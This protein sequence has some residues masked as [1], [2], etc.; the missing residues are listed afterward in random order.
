MKK[1]FFYLLTFL[2]IYSNAQIQ[3][4]ATNIV[5]T[6]TLLTVSKSG[7]NFSLTCN[8][9]SLQDVV[10]KNPTVQGLAIQSP[11]GFV[12]MNIDDTGIQLNTNGGVFEHD[13]EPIIT[14][15]NTYTLTNKT[16]SSGTLTGI[17]TQSTT[18]FTG[19]FNGTYT[20]AA[21]SNT[22]DLSTIKANYISITGTNTINSFGTVQAGAQRT[23]L[24]NG[25]LTVTSSTN[26]VLPGS[27][28]IQ[29]AANDIMVIVSDG[30]GVWRCVSY[31]K[32]DESFI[33]FPSSVTG[34]TTGLTVVSSYKMLTR[35]T[36]LF[37]LYTSVTTS[38]ATTVTFTTPFNYPSGLNATPIPIW[39][40][41]NGTSSIGY[42]TQTAG[43][44][45]C[46]VFKSNGG[47]F[48]ASGNKSIRLS[49]VLISDI[50]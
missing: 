14:D 34:F 4:K 13:S 42:F 15:A 49:V 48:T 30:S 23:I 16:I 32:A 24:F 43:S 18:N 1:I 5:S 35:N 22:L 9:Q 7:Q 38:T 12:F 6:N 40:Y 3:P 47:A 41:D 20:T 37:N 44:N 39:I 28:S 2:S 29:T 10:T 31:A 27:T 33:S 45:V 26:I 46:N 21:S 17:T 50:Q 11:S 19:A 25:T 8:G 36:Y